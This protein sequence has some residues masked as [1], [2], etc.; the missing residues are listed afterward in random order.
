VKPLK[1]EKTVVQAKSRTLKAT[2]TAEKA[3]DLVDDTDYS[4][5]ARI[6]QE[7]IDKEVIRAAAV[8]FVKSQGWTEIIVKKNISVDKEWCELYIKDEY[9]HIENYWYFKD[10]KDAHFFLLKWGS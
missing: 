6:L 9:R 7:E 3:Q 5:L 2:W 4:E 10:Q 1:I 8:E